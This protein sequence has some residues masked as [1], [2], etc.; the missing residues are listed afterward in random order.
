MI[1]SIRPGPSSVSEVSSFLPPS[2]KIGRGNLNISVQYENSFI[3]PIYVETK[4]ELKLVK[5]V[6][7]QKIGEL[8]A[9][10]EKGSKIYYGSSTDGKIFV[11]PLSIVMLIST[12]VLA[13]SSQN[14]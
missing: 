6:I 4:S 14:Y 8:K 13:L 1:Q 10:S 2:G 12:R 5:A 7:Q 11:H 3:G 9:K